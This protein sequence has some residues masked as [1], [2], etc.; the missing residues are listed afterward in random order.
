MKM[1]FLTVL[2]I[3]EVNSMDEA[4]KKLLMK[5]NL[6]TVAVFLQA[7]EKKLEN[8][9]KMLTLEWWE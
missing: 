2:Q 8:F 6:E 3:I 9:H 1:K 5:I 7:V 4:L